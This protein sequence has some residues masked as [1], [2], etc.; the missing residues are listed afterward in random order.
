[1][2]LDWLGYQILMYGPWWLTCNA[3]HAFGKWCLQRAANWV[4]GRDV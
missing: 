4:Y 3:N 2:I 1:M